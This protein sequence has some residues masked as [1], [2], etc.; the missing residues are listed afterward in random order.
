[1]HG[2]TRLLEHPCRRVVAGQ[3]RS[4][5]SLSATLTAFT[6]FPDELQTWGWSQ[7][8]FEQYYCVFDYEEGDDIGTAFRSLGLSATSKQDGGDNVCC[9][10]EHGVEGSVD[11]VPYYDQHYTVDDK[12]YHVSL[13]LSSSVHTPIHPSH[14]PLNMQSHA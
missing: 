4:R 14:S 8:H 5:V 2:P 1:M 13:V 3:A 9:S 11:H 12:Q 10:I 7:V 6:N